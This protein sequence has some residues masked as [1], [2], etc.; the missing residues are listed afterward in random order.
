MDICWMGQTG[1][2]IDF[3]AWTQA[4]GSVLAILA[5]VGIAAWQSYSSKRQALDAEI[6]EKDRL[7]FVLYQLAMNIHHFF[8]NIDEQRSTEG[9]IETYQTREY[10]RRKL[11]HFQSEMDKIPIY[12]L[13]SIETYRQVVKLKEGLDRAERELFMFKDDPID[14]AVMGCG[15]LYGKKWRPMVGNSRE[16]ME[17]LGDELK[18]FGGKH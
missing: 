10:Y 5:A 11:L 9:G 12:F 8:G 18:K 13:P 3:A 6:R 15:E 4:I 17:L 1:C 14:V 16:A 2:R 7:V